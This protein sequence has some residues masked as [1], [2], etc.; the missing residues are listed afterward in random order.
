MHVNPKVYTL[1]G[2]LSQM[3]SVVISRDVIHTGS[4]QYCLLRTLPVYY[5]K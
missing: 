4:R 1:L 2:C 5:I 3:C